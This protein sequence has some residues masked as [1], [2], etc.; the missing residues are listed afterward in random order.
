M[1][2]A[3]FSRITLIYIDYSVKERS[4]N[5]GRARVLMLGYISTLAEIWYIV[6]G[7]LTSVYL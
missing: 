6:M 5:R 2:I 1:L 4:R 7:F 3:N